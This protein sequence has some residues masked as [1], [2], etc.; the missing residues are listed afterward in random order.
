[1]S[2]LVSGVEL[3]QKGILQKYG[4][5]VLGTSIESVMATE[6]RQTFA[7]KLKDINER[8][9]PSLAVETVRDFLPLWSILSFFCP[10]SLSLSLSI[11]LSLYLSLSLSLCLLF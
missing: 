1:M 5:R 6:D 7:D 4:V 2:A 10:L 8:L 3:Y 11:S 9:A